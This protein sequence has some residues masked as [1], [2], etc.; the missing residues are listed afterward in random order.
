MLT[1]QTHLSLFP[2]HTPPIFS[3]S[4]SACSTFRSCSHHRRRQRWE[5]SR[6]RSSSTSATFGRSTAS[7]ASEWVSTTPLTSAMPAESLHASVADAIHLGCKGDH[8]LCKSCYKQLSRK[9]VCP[10]CNEAL[11][12][13]RPATF[14]N[15]IIQDLVVRCP[16]A[17]C[18]WQGPLGDREHH[19]VKV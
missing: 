2:L 14:V 13:S 5:A 4:L 3:T 9:R 16:H 18:P 12:G 8:L 11:H 15:R 1:F 7:S 19:G 6:T 17:D 10:T